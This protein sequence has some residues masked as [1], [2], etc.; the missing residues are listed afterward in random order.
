MLRQQCI[1]EA[2]AGM[3]VRL[4]LGK[5]KKDEQALK[6]RDIPNLPLTRLLESW[7]KGSASP[8]RK[9]SVV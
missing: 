4:E 8:C 1:C 2:A 6:G 7:P 3:V 9:L 5:A